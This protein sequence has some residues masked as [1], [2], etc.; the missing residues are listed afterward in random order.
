MRF[1]R[2]APFGGKKRITDKITEKEKTD[3]MVLLGHPLEYWI[4][5]QE[6]ADKLAVTDCIAEIAALRAKVSFYESR[7]DEL[8]RFKE[9]MDRV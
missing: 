9:E 4:E 7:I 5:L 3:P 2:G 6:R 1:M 8:S